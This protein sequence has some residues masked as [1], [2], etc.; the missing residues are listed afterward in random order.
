[1]GLGWVETAACTV[2][3][4]ML[5]VVVVTY[6]G[7]FLQVL[8]QR[9]GSSK[10]KRFTR[11]TRFA[12]RIWKRSGMAGIALLTP[13]LLTP[14]GGTILAISFRVHRFQILGY[15]LDSGLFWGVILTLL[16]YEVPGLK[17]LFGK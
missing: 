13:L 3:G 1:M 6:S 14:I 16:M 2:V 10:P 12:V 17:G 15:M 11:R 9:L 8:M 4:M 7:T 5:S